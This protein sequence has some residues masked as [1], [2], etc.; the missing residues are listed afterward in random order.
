MTNTRPPDLTADHLLRF[1]TAKAEYTLEFASPKAV[2]ELADLLIQCALYTELDIDPDVS[3]WAGARPLDRLDDLLE[4]VTWERYRGG[5]SRQD[6]RK[7]KGVCTGNVPLVRAR[8]KGDR[9]FWKETLLEIEEYRR[10][11][12]LDGRYGDR[13]M[14]K[15]YQL[16]KHGL[17]EGAWAAE[18][19]K[20]RAAVDKDTSIA[21]LRFS[22]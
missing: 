11:L 14:A 16:M 22:Q 21:K 6:W 4:H 8:V 9:Q 20:K 7:A 17:V 12:N 15:T 2:Y 19:F 5:L 3:Y 1:Y 10:L 13:F 18:G